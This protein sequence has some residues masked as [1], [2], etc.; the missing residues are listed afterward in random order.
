MLVIKL[1]P[2]KIPNQKNTFPS[3]VLPFKSLVWLKLTS[4]SC[5]SCMAMRYPLIFLKRHHITSSCTQALSRN[6]MKV[7]V[8]LLS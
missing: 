8:P 1:G 6:V 4:G 2:M 3:T 7:A 5:I